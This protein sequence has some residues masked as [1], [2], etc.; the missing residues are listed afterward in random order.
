MTTPEQRERYATEMA[1]IQKNLF[2]F[3]LS[4]LHDVDEANEVLQ[5]T[6]L[7]LWRKV[8]EGKEPIENLMAFAMTIARFE[9]MGYLRDRK[10]DRHL[11]RPDVI[12]QMAASAAEEFASDVDEIRALQDCLAELSASHRELIN[13][14]YRDHQTIP[15]IAAAVN[16]PAGS[17]RQAMF[18]IR[19]ALMVCMEQS[20]EGEVGR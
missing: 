2:M 15:Q 9:V 3:I 14:R 8:E 11:Y 16:R 1:K 20:V 10:R 5:N 6:N 7:T 19:K 17:V 13:R 12:E 4:L 18:R